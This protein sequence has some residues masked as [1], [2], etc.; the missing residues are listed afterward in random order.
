MIPHTVRRM[1]ILLALLGLQSG[2]RA[3]G[4]LP[5]EYQLKAAFLYNFT[6]FVEWPE[7]TFPSPSAPLV[8]TVLGR[9]PFGATLDELV[10]DKSV[11]GHQIEVHRAVPGTV[12]DGSHLLYI[13]TSERNH[14]EATVAQVG[15][16][17]ILTV[18]DLDPDDSP[19]VAISMSVGDNNRVKLTVDTGAAERAGLRISSRLLRLANIRQ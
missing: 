2:L 15:G 7:T 11:N 14:V 5:S 4:S 1:L 13:C 3:Q 10:K 8:I 17:P 12:L 16:K 6:S 18:T 9:D 19:G